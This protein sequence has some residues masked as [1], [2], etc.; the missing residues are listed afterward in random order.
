MKPARPLTPT[1]DLVL[2]AASLTKPI[3]AENPAFLYAQMPG[4]VPAYGL[5]TV[6]SLEKSGLLKSDGLGG[7]LLTP[8]GAKIQA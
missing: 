4:G 1:Q 2:R 5:R 6:K 7:Y 3:Y 8:E